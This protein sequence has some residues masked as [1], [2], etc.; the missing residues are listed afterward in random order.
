MP[1]VIVIVFMCGL[2]TRGEYWVVTVARELSAGVLGRGLNVFSSDTIRSLEDE[3]KGLDALLGNLDS[4]VLKAKSMRQT[5]Q[6]TQRL[7]ELKACRQE[8]ID[9]LENLRKFNLEV[10]TTSLQ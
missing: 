7:N 6:L 8:I 10:R 5:Q 3:R 1:I 4:P 2:S 9:E